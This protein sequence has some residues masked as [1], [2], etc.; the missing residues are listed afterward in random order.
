MNKMVAS[1][2]NKTKTQNDH[3]SQASGS[4]SKLFYKNVSPVPKLLKRFHANEQDG[5]QS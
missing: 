3:S 5:C 2:E 1:A 4:I